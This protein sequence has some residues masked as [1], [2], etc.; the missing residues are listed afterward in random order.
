MSGRRTGLTI[1]TRTSLSQ[2][3][4]TS[5]STRAEDD[6]APPCAS[7]DLTSCD[8]HDLVNVRFEAG[9]DVVPSMRMSIE[10]LV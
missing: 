9:F 8:L 2:I 3:V 5:K 4:I 6:L 10:H 1:T 7:I